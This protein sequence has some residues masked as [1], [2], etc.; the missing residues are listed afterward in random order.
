M[1][2]GKYAGKRFTQDQARARFM[3]TRA[4]EQINVVCNALR[5]VDEPTRV[6][7]HKKLDQRYDEIDRLRALAKDLF[8]DVQESFVIA[9]M[10]IKL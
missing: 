1:K 10:T 8:P 9:S 2:K 4:Q 3:W 7:A 6:E 5:C